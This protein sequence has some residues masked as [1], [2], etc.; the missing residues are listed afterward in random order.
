MATQT[1]EMTTTETIQGLFR[2]MSALTD[3]GLRKLADYAKWLA[4]EAEIAALESKYGT[5]PNA[6]TIAAIEECRAGKGKRF[7]TIEELM[8]DLHNDDED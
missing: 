4:E 8:A 2:D 1:V 7:D 3:D 5:T 6:E